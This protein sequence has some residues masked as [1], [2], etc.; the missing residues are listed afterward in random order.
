MLLVLVLL[1]TTI[2]QSYSFVY[3]L[4]SGVMANTID[5]DIRNIRR[6]K[7]LQSQEQRK[8]QRK[9]SIGDETSVSS[10]TNRKEGGGR[11]VEAIDTL[12]PTITAVSFSSSRALLRSNAKEDKGEG[13]NNNVGIDVRSV[14][15]SPKIIDLTTIE[16]EAPVEENITAVASS[17]SSSAINEKR[18]TQKVATKRKQH[19]REHHS[20]NINI[21]TFCICT[22]NLW[23]GPP[24]PAERMSEIS[25]ILSSKTPQR[26]VLVGFQEVT[27][28]LKHELCPLLESMG[29][30]LICQ[31]LDE[32]AYC[33]AIA[34][35]I[36]STHNNNR[37]TSCDD[38]VYAEI[39]DSGFRPYLQTLQG[40]GL[41]WVHAWIGS[42]SNQG[43]YVLFTTTH[44][45]SFM[46]NYPYPGQSY[47]GVKQR[48][49]QV[50]EATKFCSNYIKEWGGDGAV[51]AAIFS[52][53]LNWDDERKRSSGNDEPLLSLI[54]QS[55]SGTWKDVWLE[56]NDV[57]LSGQEG[58][59]Y[60]SKENP[61]LRGNLRRRFDRCLIHHPSKDNET[62]LGIQ[63]VDMVGTDPIKGLVWEKETPKWIG[64]KPS[65]AMTR[66]VLP[67]MPSDHYGLCTVIRLERESN[68]SK[69]KKRDN[70][71]R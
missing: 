5:D 44:L 32:S 25:S 59:T 39:V 26:P 38:G 70:F 22:Y 14:K 51:S 41:L 61:M 12:S 6:E 65:S 21:P 56:R 23:F 49:S 36:K 35:L 46:R 18:G 66:T 60:D 20:S 62:K 68:N 8:N 9:E 69:R 52:G 24:Y 4:R 13:L 64:G 34:V 15:S 2:V 10:Y 11:I 50:V 57:K 30:H 40:R 3:Q 33:C 31:N 45:E 27:P 43:G 54:D 16:E 17:S 55:D 63:S 48:A 58:Y 7:W 47:D 37:K 53:D 1:A 19:E 67:L 29:Y 71:D 28:V 42:S